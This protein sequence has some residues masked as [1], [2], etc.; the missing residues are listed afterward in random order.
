MIW[1]FRLTVNWAWATTS[2]NSAD[3]ASFT[4]DN[5]GW[6]D[7]LYRR[8]RWTHWCS[9][10]PPIVWTPATVYWS[11]STVSCYRGCRWFRTPQL[12]SSLEPEGSSTWRQCYATFTGYQYGKGSSSRRPYW[13][14][15][16]EFTTVSGKLVTINH[17]NNTNSPWPNPTRSSVYSTM[18]WMHTM[19][20]H[21][22]HTP[23]LFMNV[24]NGTHRNTNHADTE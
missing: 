24:V 23:G 17:N 13:I 5:S 6:F 3:P 7:S 11:A 10:S 9:P 12:V 22:Q 8:R 4:W 19:N 16:D 18:D 21:W 20:K 14:I 1:V 15:V 2:P